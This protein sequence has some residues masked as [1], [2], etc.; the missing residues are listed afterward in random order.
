[1]GHELCGRLKSCPEGADLKVG[2]A[3]MVDPHFTCGACDQCT[4]NEEHLCHQMGFV[5]ASGGCYGGG[6]SEYVVVDANM[7]HRLPDTIRLE[8]AAVIEPLTVAHHSIKISEINFQSESP[9]VLV[10]GG[11]PIGYAMA[12]TLRAHGAK[13]V[14]LSEPTEKRRGS[15]ASIVDVIIDPL[16]EKVGDRCRAVTGGKGVDYVFDCA[17]TKRASDDAFDA[18]RYGGRFV[19]VAMWSTS[20]CLSLSCCISPTLPISHTACQIYIPY[21]SFFRKEIQFYSSCCYN[22]QDFKE[23][24]ELIAQGKAICHRKIGV[25]EVHSS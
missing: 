19:N 20:V 24:M 10:A 8:D 23:V 3:V 14:I 11:G 13:M 18:I 1:M 22:R 5:G 12:L 6:L 2:D 9:S 17:G 25:L 16:N 21:Y 7:V 4:H 15:A